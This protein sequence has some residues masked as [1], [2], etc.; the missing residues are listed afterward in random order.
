MVHRV[1]LDL[2]LSVRTQEPLLTIFVGDGVCSVV[3]T[4]YV[5]KKLDFS[6]AEGVA[7]PTISTL[8]QSRRDYFHGCT[9]TLTT[10]LL[11]SWS[12]VKLYST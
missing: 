5:K 9:I 8:A 10:H 1:C 4:V 6:T 12:T 7:V 11:P 2:T 3:P